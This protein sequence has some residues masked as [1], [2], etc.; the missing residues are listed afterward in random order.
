VD[1][2]LIQKLVKLANNNPNDNEA[3]LAARKVCQMLTDYK[4]NTTTPRER[5]EFVRYYEAGFN[6]YDDFKSGI[7]WD[8]MLRRARAR[9]KVYEKPKKEETKW[10]LCLVCRGL[11]Y[12][13]NMT[14]EI[15]D[16]CVKAKKYYKHVEDDPLNQNRHYRCL[17]HGKEINISYK[18]YEM[19]E[20]KLN[21]GMHE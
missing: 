14:F 10:K 19:Y 1:I 7:D 21:C 4:F 13:V 11:T 18:A 20:G 9:E 6:P 5:G 8:E 12:R 17:L 2:D 16:A 3:N 15:C